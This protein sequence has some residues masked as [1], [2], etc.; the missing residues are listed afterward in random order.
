MRGRRAPV[1]NGAA[2]AS[3]AP[4]A[5]ADV[6]FAD[7][8]L[9]GAVEE[10][11][12]GAVERSRKIVLEGILKRSCDFRGKFRRDAPGAPVSFRVYNA[13]AAAEVSLRAPSL[14]EKGVADRPDDRSRSNPRDSS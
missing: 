14:I 9:A 10:M 2:A 1:D 4:R 5:A 6:A 12:C 7:A 13:A 3:G 11:D 8:V